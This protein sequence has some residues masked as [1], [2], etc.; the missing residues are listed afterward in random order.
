MMVGLIK[1]KKIIALNKFMEVIMI[2]YVTHSWSTKIEMVEIERET[3]A[4]VVFKNGRREAKKTTCWPNWKCYFDT[5]SEA[6]EHILKIRKNKIEDFELRIEIEK[7]EIEE[8]NKI[9]V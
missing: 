9:E 5:K 8:I 3:D 6:K 1:G 2:K 4:F 7:K